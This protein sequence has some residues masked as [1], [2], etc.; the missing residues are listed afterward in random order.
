[1][2][3]LGGRE[4]K[5]ND[6]QKLLLGCAGRRGGEILQST[7]GKKKEE[8]KKVIEYSK[9]EIKRNVGR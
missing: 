5:V 9:K 6:I 7:P 1:M 8:R 3:T 4:R 2:K